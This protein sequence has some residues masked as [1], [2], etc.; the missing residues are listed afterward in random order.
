MGMFTVGKVTHYRFKLSDITKL[1][2]GN[3]LKVIVF[4][5]YPSLFS[6]SLSTVLNVSNYLVKN[7]NNIAKLT[8]PIR[9]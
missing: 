2:V 6:L 7:L 5:H 4:I 3:I 8:F 1:W 9:Q